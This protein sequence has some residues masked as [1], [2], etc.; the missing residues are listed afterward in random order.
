MGVTDGDELDDYFLMYINGIDNPS[1]LSDGP[2]MQRFDN[3]KGRVGVRINFGLSSPRIVDL[4]ITVETRSR[5][6]WTY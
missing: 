6:K 5:S 4:Q 3:P 2:L 1:F